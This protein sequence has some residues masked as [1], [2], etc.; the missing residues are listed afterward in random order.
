MTSEST[1]LALRA[2]RG[3]GEGTADGEKR[4]LRLLSAYFT[5]QTEEELSS[6]GQYISLI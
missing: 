2:A 5:Y 3:T 6:L 4:A 1:Y